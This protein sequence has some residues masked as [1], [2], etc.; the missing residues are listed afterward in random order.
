MEE[1]RL[2]VVSDATR[3]FPNNQNNHFKV[4]LPRP[5]TL[6]DEPWAMSLW[7][8]SVPDGAVEQPFG[9][10][11]DIT[12]V[13]AGQMVCI[14]NYKNGK[15][16]SH[17]TNKTLLYVMQLKE[18]FKTHPK[19]GVELWQRVHQIM[20]EQQTKEL[21]KERA[22]SDWLVQQP[23]KWF[24]TIRWEGEDMILE[25]IYPLPQDSRSV[26]VHEARPQ[27]RDMEH[28]TQF[29]SLVS[30]VRV[31]GPRHHLSRDGSEPW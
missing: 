15:Y 12:A 20:L 27:D 28:W 29:D 23:E 16:R 8:L 10:G 6:P 17:L 13:F 19:T 31:H 1:L 3:E 9:K 26:W 4:R 7:S 5:L 18:P 2:T 14:W 22:L 11:S 24:P 30:Q 25:A 21:G